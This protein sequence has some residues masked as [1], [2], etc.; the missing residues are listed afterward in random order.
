MV[1]KNEYPIDLFRC[2]THQTLLNTSVP[3]NSS[4]KTCQATLTCWLELWVLG[5]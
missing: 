4:D 3:W 1:S 5:T 2:V